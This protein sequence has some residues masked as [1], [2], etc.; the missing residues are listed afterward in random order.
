MTPT[1]SPT[2]AG[3]SCA[4]PWLEHPAPTPTHALFKRAAITCLLLL[5]TLLTHAH[6]DPPRP[7]RVSIQYIEVT[8]PVLTELLGSPSKG[9]PTLHGKALELCKSGK[10]KILETSVVV[11]R[12][13][14]RA[15]LESIREFIYP[16]EYEPTCRGLF[17][18][19]DDPPK[20]PTL[21]PNE[22]TSFETR[23]TGVTLEVEPTLAADGH[24]IELR[25]VPEIVSLTGLTNWMEHVDE[26]GTN[27]YFMP[28]FECWRSNTSLTLTDGQ[29]EL[30]AVI[31][32]KPVAPPPA[33]LRKILLFV[34]ADIITPSP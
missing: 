23:N 22:F 8:Q 2:V 16:A 13:G 24:F 14:Q 7:I 25:F 28:V 30:V 3:A 5:T 31:T 32:P 18:P 12:S 9:G 27:H 1:P 21:R 20:L 15:T 19:V 4:S 6:A 33:A 26:W 29:F 34:R 10:G 17:G 11:C